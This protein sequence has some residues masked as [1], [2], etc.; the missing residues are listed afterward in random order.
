MQS[1]WAPSAEEEVNGEEGRGRDGGKVLDLLGADGGCLRVV[2]KETVVAGVPV[3]D[4][5]GVIG[6]IARTD[7]VDDLFGVLGRGGG[8]SAWIYVDLERKGGGGTGEGD[9]DPGGVSKII[10]SVRR[11][12]R[13]FS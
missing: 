2:F 4:V 9:R 7:R 1:A 13:R 3:R 12:G 5:G 8:D 6:E 11:L 10:S